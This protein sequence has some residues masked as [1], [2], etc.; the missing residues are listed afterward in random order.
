MHGAAHQHEQKL[1]NSCCHNHAEPASE[2]PESEQSHKH[3]NCSLCQLTLVSVILPELWV[4]IQNTGIVLRE[5]EAVLLPLEE[6]HVH[7]HQARAPPFQLI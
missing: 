1:E 5:P 3:H 4:Q 6:I 2:L 7:S